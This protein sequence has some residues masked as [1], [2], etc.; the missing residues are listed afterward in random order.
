MCLKIKYI[1]LYKRQYKSQNI[2]LMSKHRTNKVFE[3]DYLINEDLTE[4]DYDMATSDLDDLD[5][6]LDELEAMLNG[7][8]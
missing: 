4:E 6:Q 3:I 5:S 7:S 8:D 2:A 1:Y